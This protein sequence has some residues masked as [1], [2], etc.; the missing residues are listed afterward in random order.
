MESSVLWVS[1]DW[2]F[3][4]Q[5]SVLG[6]AQEWPRVPG[7]FGKHQGGQWAWSS[8]CSMERRLT[9]CH[10]GNWNNQA[11]CL[12]SFSRLAWPYSHGDVHRSPKSIKTKLTTIQ[13]QF[14]S[15]CW[16]HICDCPTGQ[17]K[18]YGQVE[19]QCGRGLLPQRCGYKEQNFYS[20]FGQTDQTYYSA[21]TL[22][23]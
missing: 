10:L 5:R 13:K 20:H 11:A 16:S 4:I 1:G 19:S 17:G 21:L 6:K 8:E 9:S 14:S 3:Q 12:S 18:F 23:N 15:L 22:L 7:V 2:A